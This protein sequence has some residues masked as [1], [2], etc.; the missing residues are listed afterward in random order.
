MKKRVRV[1]VARE[2]TNRALL[3]L[4]VVL[5]LVALPV[6]FGDYPVLWNLITG[7]AVTATTSAAVAVNSRPV[8]NYTALVNLSGAA[9]SISA[10]TFQQVNFTFEVYDADGRSDIDNSTARLAINITPRVS[11]GDLY[12]INESRYNTTCQANGTQQNEDVITFVCSVYIWYWDAAGAWTINASVNDF[13]GPVTG[14]NSTTMFQL[15]LT[16]ALVISPTALTWPV[17]EL[18]YTNRTSSN[19]PIRINNTGNRNVGVAN[20]TVTGSDLERNHTLNSLT[21]TYPESLLRAQNFS[22]R[23]FNA[24]AAADCNSGAGVNCYECNGTQLLNDTT[25]STNP[26][27]LPFANMTAGNN[28]LELR[29][30]TSGQEELFV[31]LRLVPDQTER[32]LYDTAGN[33]TTSWVVSIYS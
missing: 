18:G 4:V 6:F 24:T 15:S 23:H 30:G 20:F 21:P 25:G 33:W 16:T 19:D 5:V 32:G 7:Q 31:C 2:G 13:N 11:D 10:A 14:E 17:L 3:V 8:I 9:I 28:S 22:I 29:N 26:Q 1:N 12:F 27:A